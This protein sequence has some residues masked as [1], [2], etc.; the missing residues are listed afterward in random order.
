MRLVDHEGLRARQDLAEALLLERQVGQ[1]QVMVDHHHVGRLCTLARLHHETVVPERALVAQAVVDG[2][3]DHRVQ[4]RV[5]RQGFQLGHV[6]EAA[7]PGPGQD[8]LELRHLLRRTEAGF[9]TGLLQAV[10]AQI[11]RT[12]LEQRTAVAHPERRAHPRQ[13]AVV[14]L[15]LQRAGA[16]GNDD[17]QPRQQRRHQ[18]RIGL[19]GAGTGLGQQ[20]VALVEGFGDGNRQA[21]LRRASNEGIQLAGKRPTL[22]EGF[23]AGMGK[24]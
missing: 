18:V 2:G 19:A 13:V 14:Q 1:Q 11:V 22:A 16:G 15:V 20:H 23:A 6:A 21:Q 24:A 17:L 12:A 3:G 10:A 8:A 4:R 9:A 5:F 7:A